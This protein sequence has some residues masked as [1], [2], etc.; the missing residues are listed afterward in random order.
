MSAKEKS[1]VKL[2]PN[3]LEVFINRYSLRDEYAKPVESVEDIFRRVARVVA[4]SENKYR[5]GINPKDVRNDFY[6]ALCDLRFLPNGRS[7]ANSGAG[8]GQLANCF[9]LPIDDDMGRLEHSIF[10][11]LRDAVLI[12]QSGGGVGFS[13][14]RIR[15]K[16]APIKTTKGKATGAV[17]F[18]KIYDTAFWVIGQGGARRAACMAVLPVHHPDVFDF[19][20]CKENEGEIEHFNIS[21]GITDEF[22]EAV[23]NDK[24][25]NLIDPHSQE[26]VRRVKAR[27]L[28][29]EI[30]LLAHHNG[31]P[32]MLFLDAA[33]KENP[34][35]GQYT[36]EATNPCFIG[37]TRIPSQFGLLKIEELSR[38]KLPLKTTIDTRVI[39]QSSGTRVALA[40]HAFLTGKNKPVYKIT[41]QKGY[42][43]T[44]TPNHKLFTPT[45]FQELKDLQIGSQLSL[46][47]GVGIWSQNYLL[48]NLQIFDFQNQSLFIQT[49]GSV[50]RLKQRYPH[51]PRKWSQALGVVIG[52]LV[53]DGWIT[54]KSNSPLGF[55]FGKNE[56]G[57]EG[58]EIITNFMK[59]Y[60][61]GGCLAERSR[62]Y[63]LTYGKTPATFFQT[64]GVA[65]AKAAHKKA[66]ESI[67]GAPK[68]TV[69]GFLQGLFSADGTVQV[70]SKKQNCSIRLASSSRLLLEDVQL[71]LINFGIASSIHKRRKAQTKL[72]PNAHNRLSAYQT[73]DQYELIIG[74]ANRDKFA[75]QIGFALTSKQTKLEKFIRNMK[76]QAYK[77]K[78][79]DTVTSIKYVG[80][81]DVYDL[82]QPT[83]HSLIANGI[84][85]H[86]C[87]E[88]WLGPGENCCMASVNL[89]VHVKKT[90][91]PA[92]KIFPYEID[93]K[94][95]EKTIHTTTRFLDDVID[96]NKY[97]SAVPLL[98]E[99]AWKNRRIG[100]S[101]M[102]LADMMYQVGVPYGSQAGEDLAGQVMEFIRFHTLKASIDLARMRGAFPGITDSIYN[103]KNFTYK[104]N[105]HLVKPELKLKR[106]NLD[107]KILLKEL[108]RDGVRNAAQNTIAPTGAIA[109]VAG[110]EGYGCEPVF[111][112]SYI[113]KTHEGMDEIVT[114]NSDAAAYK[115]LY[116]ESGLFKEALVRAGLSPTQ[117]EKIFV[118]IRKTGTCQSIKE[119]P[120]AIR[121]V[122]VVSSDLTA[123]QHVRM[124][125]ALQ[126]FID[127]SISKTINFP[128]SA[129]VEDVQKAYLLAHKL[130]CKGITV[131]VTGSRK[132]VVLEAGG[133]NEAKSKEAT[134]YVTNGKDDFR[135]KPLIKKKPGENSQS[136]GTE[137]VCPECSTIMNVAEGCYTCPKCAYSKCDV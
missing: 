101:I 63:Q 45:G 23:K 56:D 31:E 24:M 87:G 66:P 117:Q 130:G 49:G 67:F 83:T 100:V 21:V 113:M 102:G 36:L 32:G 16:G 81:Q 75:I 88:Q 99:A 57:L 105:K 136:G 70:S 109:T 35:P 76:R 30:A 89:K 118:K 122:F 80:K 73:Q 38:L 27:K 77:E 91:K 71:L 65:N 116:Y 37:S 85:A 104:L 7:I 3:A 2:P 64:L 82:T 54:A 39:G 43:V 72:M 6:N 126:R 58:L 15:H 111:S 19:I 44:V 48:P 119:V 33:N 128:N 51:I 133:E 96:A 84:L 106:P 135:G 14:G 125:A 13:F 4:E 95:L 127:N 114:G 1:K 123:T 112:L 17:S 42:T 94:S 98:Q 60:F 108:K 12:L 107:W 93:W 131:Y 79:I 132:H 22:M 59:Q 18:L 52:W 55:S 53:G 121:K 25:F 129:Q 11:T 97:V 34:V 29:D 28:F 124:Q 10:S 68:E 47:S 92:N 86:N 134:P 40:T 61:S 62:S 20:H 41:T 46:Q 110:L 120:E 90:T 78:F 103:K 69:I 8:T 9:V 74:K 115:S 50:A 26:V 137:A 5:D